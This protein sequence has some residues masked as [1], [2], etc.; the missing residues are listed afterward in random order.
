MLQDGE[1]GEFFSLSQSL[2][3]YNDTYA[4]VEFPLTKE[5]VLKKGWQWYDEPK[6]PVDLKGMGLIQAKD[7]PKDIKDVKDDILNKAIVC[8]VSDKPFRI[9]KSELEF[10]RKHNL[11]IPTKHPYQRMMERFKKRNPT[12]LWEDT[13]DKCSKEMLTSYPPKK[14]KELKI[15]CKK[16]YQKEVG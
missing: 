13:C 11:P 8:E 6:I 7:L 9:I 15:Y 3:P 10:Y 1:Y 16:C 2:H 14:Q 4:M 12:R 5:E